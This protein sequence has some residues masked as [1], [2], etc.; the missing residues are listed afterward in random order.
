M[1]LYIKLDFNL[2]FMDIDN[3]KN[4]NDH[5]YKWTS[6]NPGPDIAKLIA[7]NIVRNGDEI[8]QYRF[9]SFMELTSIGKKVHKEIIKLD[10]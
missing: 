8:G 10:L 6:P 5:K 7:L 1:R 4:I 9:D 3:I 2:D